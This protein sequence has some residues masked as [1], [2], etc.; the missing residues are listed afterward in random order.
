M[1][2]KIIVSGSL[3]SVKDSESEIFCSGSTIEEV[4]RDAARKYPDIKP[5]LFDDNNQPNPFFRI[6]L[7]KT[8]IGHLLQEKTKVK[9]GDEIIILPIMVGG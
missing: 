4:L 3:S 7:N 1:S 9:P 6:F 8:H 2:V 5:P